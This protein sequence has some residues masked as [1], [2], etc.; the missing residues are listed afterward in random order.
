MKDIT[1]ITDSKIIIKIFRLVSLNKYKLQVFQDDNTLKKTDI[2]VYDNNKF[3]AND[4]IRYKSIANKI[5][6]LDKQRIK[7]YDPCYFIKKPFL[8]SQL[9]NNLNEI[10]KNDDNNNEVE[11]DFES[12]SI[13]INKDQLGHGGVLDKEEL[14]LLNDMINDTVD[15]LD[16]TQD[17]HDW[18]ELSDII[19]KAIDETGKYD[20]EDNFTLILNRYSADELTPL[21]NRCDK[22]IIDMLSSNKEV[23]IKLKLKD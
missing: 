23:T 3:N 18:L 14:S 16:T 11:I 19:D 21:L 6:V 22:K 2:L 12:N 1:L 7:E 8:P 4:I 17:D 15:T 9:I 10:F 5:I 20:L 13:N